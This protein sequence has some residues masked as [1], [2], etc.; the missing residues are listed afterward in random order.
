MSEIQSDFV[1]IDLSGNRFHGSIPIT[2]GN[3]GALHVLNM[4]G[5]ASTGEIPHELGNLVRLES[6]DLSWNRLSGAIPEELAASLT[7]LEWQNLSYNTLSGRIPS[8]PQFS[9]FPSS[10]FQGNEG[11]YGCPFLLNAP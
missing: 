2:I 5:N 1:L 11:L 8:G 10:S 6:L 3:L 7:S 4:S 9:T